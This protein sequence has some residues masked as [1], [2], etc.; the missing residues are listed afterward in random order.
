MFNMGMVFWAG[1]GVMQDYV[2]ARKWFLK[3][4]DAGEVSAFVE[5]G[6]LYINGYGVEQDI[7]EAGK[8]LLKAAEAGDA[9]SQY[10]VGY[11]YEEGA[12]MTKDR[13]KA[14]QWYKKAAKQDI[15][16]AQFKVASMLM[17]DSLQ[18]EDEAII[19][20]T[21][22]A[23]LGLLPAMVNLGIIRYTR[24]EYADALKW[25]QTASFKNDPDAQFYLGRLYI[26]GKGVEKDID[27]GVTWLRVSA[28][29]GNKA[30]KDIIAR[31]EGHN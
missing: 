20:Y 5:L 3:A 15:P 30:A 28:D 21:K 2:E 23:N 13:D 12:G 31:V 24:A 22:A 14:F 11:M 27:K 26:E 6:M 7:S 1:A 16:D 9:L 8:W 18:N 25:F 4:A 10:K 17:E 29:N 19:W